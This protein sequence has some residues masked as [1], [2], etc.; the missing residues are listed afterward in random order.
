MNRLKR[1]EFWDILTDV[2]WDFKYVDY[3]AV[4][5]EWLS[6]TG[7]I[8]L[9][10]WKKWDEPYK[11]AYNEYVA[12]QSEKD[13]S[14]YA[15]KSALSKSKSF[16][17]LAPGWKSISKAHY[18]L[19]GLIEYIAVFGELKMAR[20]GLSPN[21]R[22]VAVY[23]ALDEIRHTQLNLSFAHE[24][25]QK[26]PQYDFC[27]RAYHTEN[28]TTVAG[29]AL[30]D[31]IFMNTNAVDM[32]IAAPFVF[33]TGFT[34]VQLLGMSADAIEAGDINFANMI[35][36]IQ[37]DEA[38]H[39]QQGH[40]T[41]ELLVEHDPKRAQWIIDKTFWFSARAFSALTGPGMD[42]DTPLENRKKSYKEFMLEWIVDQFLRQI[43]DYGLKEPWY[44][45]E[46]IKGLDSWHHELHLGLWRWRPTLWWN[47]AGGLSKDEREWLNEKYPNIEK[48]Y[49][50]AW[51][52]IINNIN[53]GKIE[54]GTLPKTLP[55]LCNACHLPIGSCSVPSSK[56]LPVRAYNLKHNGEQ[57]KFCS[58][59]CRQIWWEDRDMLHQ[60]SLIDRLL[61]GEIED[62]T[63]PGVLDYMGMTPNRNME[64]MIMGDDATGYVWAKDYVD[65]KVA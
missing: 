39:A 26:D 32:A 55:W 50:Y 28:W 10:E 54:E 4:F 31:G 14:A 23:G 30:F 58:K 7:K 41:L 49:G 3:E 61:T 2:E 34:N 12:T 62:P 44:W 51:D 9:E 5:P 19:I 52:M 38:R 53:S 6:G 43:R 13:K 33:E 47:P 22:N 42:Y 17:S 11:V 57:H 8:P 15:V 25:V 24:L 20:F 36:S 60:K 18:G 29:R 48:D 21:W 35:S 63:V 46:F 16:E 56:D 45:D 37:T 59:V 65:E 1:E 27:Q 40:P 64:H